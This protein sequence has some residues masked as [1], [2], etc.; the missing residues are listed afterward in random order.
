M[1]WYLL[2]TWAGREEELLRV[3]RR[4]VP[5]SLCKECF[6]ID[7]ERIWIRQKR[8]ILHRELLFP[9]CVFF[10]TPQSDPILSRIEQIPAIDRW[11]VSKSL[12]ILRMTEEDGRFLEE[13]SGKEHRVKLSYVLKDEQGNICKLSGP[14]S[15]YQE[16]IER[17]QFKKRYAMI[18]HRLWGEERTFVLGILLKEDVNQ[19]YLLNGRLAEDAL[20]E[21]SFYRKYGDFI[22]GDDIR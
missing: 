18:R 16:Y 1:Q 12:S 11:I 3:I 4:S 21:Y 7:Q 8:N 19:E 9:G 17:I 14:L 15:D 13:L 10:I 20:A 6:M 5:D 22:D 2:K